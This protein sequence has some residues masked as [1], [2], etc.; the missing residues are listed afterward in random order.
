MGVVSGSNSI[1]NSTSLSGGNPGKSS[2]KISENSWT[3]G[4]EVRSEE[5]STFAATGEVG[6]EGIRRDILSSDTGSHNS[7]TL[8][9]RSK[10][11]T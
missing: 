2:G 7:T 1:V 9:L 6:S 11:I 10:T 4:I 3:T 8:R 5:T